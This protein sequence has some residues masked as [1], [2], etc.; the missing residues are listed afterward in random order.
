[1]GLDSEALAVADVVTVAATLVRLARQRD[2]PPVM[3][4]AHGHRPRGGPPGSTTQELISTAPLA[5]Q[6]RHPYQFEVCL[7]PL[8]GTEF[9]RLALVVAKE[10]AERLDLRIQIISAVARGKDVPIRYSELANVGLGTELSI[11][12]VVDLDPAGA[13]HET[14]NASTAPLPAWPATAA[15]AAQISAFLCPTT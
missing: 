13:I 12:V 8:D 15:V 3:V 7:V 5:A 14:S 2:A 6:A 4:G 1:M 10:L 9:A 11:S